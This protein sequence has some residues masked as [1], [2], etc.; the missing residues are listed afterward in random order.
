MH[1]EEDRKKHIRTLQIILAIVLALCVVAAGAWGDKDGFRWL[2]S[3]AGFILLSN[4]FAFTVMAIRSR[5]RSSVFWVV[6]A[7]LL[8]ILIIFVS[9]V[10]EENSA[11]SILR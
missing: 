11:I 5:A 8:V 7:Y 1:K 6:F 9:I 3:V 10:R 2:N 4:V